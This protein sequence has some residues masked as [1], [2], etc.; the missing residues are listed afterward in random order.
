MFS[1]KVVQSEYRKDVFGYEISKNW[2]SF[3]IWSANKSN[4]ITGNSQYKSKKGLDH[5]I[6]KVDIVC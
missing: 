3:W 5:I 4:D 6:E 1:K 2:N